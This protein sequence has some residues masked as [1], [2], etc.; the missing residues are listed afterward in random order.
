MPWRKPHA[1][2]E[3]KREKPMLRAFVICTEQAQD[4]VLSWPSEML[5]RSAGMRCTQVLSSNRFHTLSKPL[6]NN[7]E[8]P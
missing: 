4:A 6:G 8:G 5:K 1:G 2:I 3:Y 7:E